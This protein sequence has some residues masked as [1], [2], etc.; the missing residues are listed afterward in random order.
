MNALFLVIKKFWL[1]TIR[2]IVIYIVIKNKNK[3]VYSSLLIHKRLLKHFKLNYL[4][5]I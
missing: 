1:H 3:N 2:T 5:D 4:F